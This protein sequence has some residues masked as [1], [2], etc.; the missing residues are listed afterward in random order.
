MILLDEY[1]KKLENLSSFNETLL[2]DKSKL[3]ADLEGVKQRVAEADVRNHSTT[4][5]DSFSTCLDD[6]FVQKLFNLPIFHG[7]PM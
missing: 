4:Y 7:L 1:Q 2:E 3:K 6:L 5:H